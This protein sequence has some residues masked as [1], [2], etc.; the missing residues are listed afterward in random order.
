MRKHRGE[1]P[2]MWLAGADSG[3]AFQHDVGIAAARLWCRNA[4]WPTEREIAEEAGTSLET[5]GCLADGLELRERL[6]QLEVEELMRAYGRLRQSGRPARDALAA[7]ARQRAAAWYA[8]DSCLVYFPLLT[9]I[10][11]RSRRDH[12]AACAQAAVAVLARQ[13]GCTP[14][15]GEAS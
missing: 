3:S 9:C 11:V 13:P 7:A 14:I 10:A 15:H 5:L 6:A 2:S 12:Q 1:V 4:S 8:I